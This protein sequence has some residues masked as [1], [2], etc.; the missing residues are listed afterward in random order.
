M[1]WKNI[2]Y[3]FRGAVISTALGIFIWIIWFAFFYKDIYYS[4]IRGL[5]VVGALVLALFSIIPLWLLGL[6]IGWII[7]KLKQK[8]A[9]VPKKKK[10]KR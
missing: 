5:A 1:A 4:D 2:S 6:F 7:G 8:D 3:E 9:I 10:R